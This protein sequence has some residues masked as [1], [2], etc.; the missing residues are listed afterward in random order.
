MVIHQL[1]RHPMI[2]DINIEFAREVW[3]GEGLAPDV[4]RACDEL[5]VKN[6]NSLTRNIKKVTCCHCLRLIKRGGK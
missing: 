3:I 5:M 2:D 6:R 4:I 1:K